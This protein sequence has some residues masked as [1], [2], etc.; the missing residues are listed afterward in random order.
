MLQDITVTRTADGVC[1]GADDYQR[2]LD[3][4]ADLMMT[5]EACE[6]RK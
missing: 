3:N 4:L 2:L 5:A 6:D 1:M